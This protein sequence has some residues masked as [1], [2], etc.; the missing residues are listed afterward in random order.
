MPQLDRLRVFMTVY[1]LESITR[2]AEQLHLTQP[3]VTQQL[4]SL[5]RHLG[6]QL[7]TRH[8]RGV[9]ATPAGHA[10]A[11]QVGP[12]LQSLISTLSAARGEADQL[13]GHV[14][15]GGASGI[16]SHR[17]VP[18]LQRLEH[19]I[20][21]T[22]QIGATEAL[23]ERLLD[24]K[25]DLHVAR[26]RIN[27]PEV[28]CIPF[29]KSHVVLVGHPVWSD[30]PLAQIPVLESIADAPIVRAYWMEVFQQEPSPPIL[31][32]TDF[33]VLIAAAAQGM[34]LTALP[35]YLAE[36]PLGTGQLIVLHQPARAPANTFFLVHRKDEVQARVLFTRDL[37]L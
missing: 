8:A 14:V 2:A 1:H 21:F 4:Q 22:F 37:L 3:S 6:V 12:P 24:G 25:L 31:Q 18:R 26:S 36:G 33:Q 10:L 27:H 5:E 19:H 11:R 16:L 9:R 20:Q 28:V 35:S 23:Q 15:I 13:A 17:V 29:H 30:V 7:F 32:S 34:G